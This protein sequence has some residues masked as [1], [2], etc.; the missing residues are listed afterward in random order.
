MRFLFRWLMRAFLALAALAAGGAGLAYYLAGQ[1]L[2]DY[3]RSYVLDGPLGEIEIVRDRNAVPHILAAQDADAFFGLGFVH[4]QDRL[5]QMT[6]MRRTVQGRLSEIFGPET[7]EIDVLMRALDL[8]GLSREAV[9][10]QTPETR[11]ALEA[12]AAGINAWLRV[13]QDEALG[14]GAPE[15]FLF[16]PSI[17]PWTPA[18]SIAVQKLMALQLTDKAARETQRQRAGVRR[19][20]AERDRRVPHALCGPA[21]RRHADA[22]RARGTAAAARGPL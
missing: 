16:D 2:P 8:Y 7:V 3:D 18:D 14:R 13:V 4:A 6:L 12:Y 5:W 10:V 19:D 15:F 1:S 17:A 9:E 20:H 21:G 22:G 11:A